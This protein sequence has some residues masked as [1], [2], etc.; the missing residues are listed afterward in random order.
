MKRGKDKRKKRKRGKE[1]VRGRK[2]R[3]KEKEER[4]RRHM[5]RYNTTAGNFTVCLII[6]QIQ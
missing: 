1:G 3:R 5:C 4:E 2:K 6:L